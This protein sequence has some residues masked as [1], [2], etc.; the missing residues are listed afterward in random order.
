MKYKYRIIFNGHSDRILRGGERE[1]RD[2]KNSETALFKTA[3]SA[4]KTFLKTIR[5]NLKSES[6]VEFVI[7]DYR[8]EKMECK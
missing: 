2:F 8:I 7:Y 6:N 4:E 1:H 5:E 3:E